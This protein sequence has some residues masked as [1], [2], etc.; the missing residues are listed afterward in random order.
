MDMDKTKRINLSH[1][2]TAFEII[3]ENG[4]KYE[5]T[6]IGYRQ[7]SFCGTSCCLWGHAALVAG[8]YTAKEFSKEKE[9]SNFWEEPEGPIFSELSIQC[10]KW[11]ES[12]RSIKRE[13]Y[14]LMTKTTTTVEEFEKVLK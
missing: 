7:E 6:N 10:G 4:K 1:V 5:E 8:R 13:L 14:S 2:R 12:K 11:R 3:K 9:S